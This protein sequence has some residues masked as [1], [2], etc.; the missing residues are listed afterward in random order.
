M[1]VAQISGTGRRYADEN[2]EFGL[3][4]WPWRQKSRSKLM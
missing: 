2:K 1:Y 4:V 3:L